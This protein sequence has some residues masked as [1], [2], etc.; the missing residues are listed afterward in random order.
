MIRVSPPC[1]CDNPRRTIWKC[2]HR[3]S[4]TSLP[5]LN[6]LL[7]TIDTNKNEHTRPIN[8]RFT[9]RSNSESAETP[10]FDVLL[11][12][13]TS[14]T[15]GKTPKRAFSRRTISRN[16]HTRSHCAAWLNFAKNNTQEAPKTWAIC[17]R[18]FWH[19][20]CTRRHIWWFPRPQPG[21]GHRCD[22]YRLLGYLAQGTKLMR[23][24]RTTTC[25]A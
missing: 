25:V 5:V 22:I 4:K 15:C 6:L 16:K 7:L 8:L 3:W 1:L 13:L 24:I 19:R 17:D 21:Q 12:L 20:R 9:I 23:Y 11:Q 14:Y 18:Q 2:R 10:D